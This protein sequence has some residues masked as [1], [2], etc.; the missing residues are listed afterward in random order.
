MNTI[1]LCGS[2]RST[3]VLSGTRVF[4]RLLVGELATPKLA[5]IFAYGKW[6]YHAECYYTA[7]QIWTKDV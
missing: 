6:L 1:F 3:G 7:R 5:Q 4:L 2:R